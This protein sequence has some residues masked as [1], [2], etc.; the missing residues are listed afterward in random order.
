MESET[1]ARV[2]S[3]LEPVTGTGHVRADVAADLDFSQVE[4]T[5]EK[6][7]PQS[8]VMRSQQTSSEQR[9]G[10]AAQAASPA[11]GPTIRRPRWQRQPLLNSCTPRR[12]KNGDHHKL[13]DRQNGEAYDLRRRRS[14]QS[15]LRVGSC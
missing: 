15:S 7:N 11:L 5:E 12:S 9:N 14:D 4:Q 2:I 8:A 10:A 1:A 6:Y 3:L 13:G